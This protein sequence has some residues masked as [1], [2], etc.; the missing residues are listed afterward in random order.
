MK[1]AKNYKICGEVHRPEYID[2]ILETLFLHPKNKWLTLN[3]IQEVMQS[4]SE[5]WFHEQR[6]RLL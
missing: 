1:T 4:Q 3:A 5:L 6:G 2:Q